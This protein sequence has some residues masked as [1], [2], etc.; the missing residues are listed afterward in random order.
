MARAYW[1]AILMSI[2]APELVSAVFF[3]S[4][5]RPPQRT[6]SVARTCLRPKP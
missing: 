6:R 3:S 5:M 1:V 2:D 4:A